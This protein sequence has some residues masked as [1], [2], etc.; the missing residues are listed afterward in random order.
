MK[1]ELFEMTDKEARAFMAGDKV[2]A[3]EHVDAEGY[4]LYGFGISDTVKMRHYE[5]GVC[6][7]EIVVPSDLQ[8][9]PCGIRF[10]TDRHD[11]CPCCK[12]SIRDVMLRNKTFEEPFRKFEAVYSKL[13]T[14][15]LHVA[16]PIMLYVADQ[17]TESEANT[18]Y[19]QAKEK[20]DLISVESEEF[21]FI[22][23]EG[24]IERVKGLKEDFGSVKAMRCLTRGDMTDA[25]IQE[26]RS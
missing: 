3:L 4:R 20:F 17:I 22:F 23:D 25:S 2:K 9:V 21:N 7:L 18:K 8:C 15:A 1:I 14:Q 10:L 6:K 19:L 24:I 13:L 26:F 16:Q 11:S 12:S 5:D